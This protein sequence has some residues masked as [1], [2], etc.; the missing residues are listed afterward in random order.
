MDGRLA[1]P[2]VLELCTAPASTL[3]RSAHCTSSLVCS[4]KTAQKSREPLKFSKDRLEVLRLPLNPSRTMSPNLLRGRSDSQLIG[5]LIL[6][7]P[8]TLKDSTSCPA[9][10]LPVADLTVIPNHFGLCNPSA[11]VSRTF[12]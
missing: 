2:S 11:T 5:L 6:R 12:K 9:S 4:R 10:S 1:P 3:S 7:R 8:G